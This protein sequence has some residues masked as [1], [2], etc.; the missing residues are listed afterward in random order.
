MR[1]SQIISIAFTFLCWIV[2]YAP[3]YAQSS[4]EE[5]ELLAFLVRFYETCVQ[6]DAEAHFQ[7]WARSSPQI[8]SRR[9]ELHTL[10]GNYEELKGVKIHFIENND[11]VTT[12]WFITD[13]QIVNP[14]TTPQKH[15]ISILRVIECV[16]EN[17]E[18][19]VWRYRPAS[20]VLAEKL[21]VADSSEERQRIVQRYHSFV[22]PD[23]FPSL[24]SKLVPQSSY[25]TIAELLS[26]IEKGTTI[27]QDIING[28]QPLQEARYQQCVKAARILLA[29]SLRAK[30]GLIRDLG[31]MYTPRTLL[32]Q[33]LVLAR[34][35]NHPLLEA[36]VLNDLGGLRIAFGE[37]AEGIEQMERGLLL[38]KQ[39]LERA[40]ADTAMRTGYFV[41]ANHLASAYV[42]LGVLSKGQE[43][44]KDVL[45][46]A[47]AL[48]EKGKLGEMG[49]LW[50]LGNIEY[51]FGRLKSAAEYYQQSLDLARSVNHIGWIVSNLSC[52]IDLLVQQGKYQ[53]AI[54]L[55]EEIVQQGERVGWTNVVMGGLLHLV[56]IHLHLRQYEH[57]RRYIR[58][59]QQI[60]VSI[61]PKPWELPLLQGRLLLQQGRPADALSYFK[62][63][64]TLYERADTTRQLQ[65][66]PLWNLRPS[67]ISHPA[68]YLA[69]CYL[70][71]GRAKDALIAWEKVQGQVL[72]QMP[73][74]RR[75]HLLEELPPLDKQQ[76]QEKEQRLR[77][78]TRVLQMMSRQA[79]VD[80]RLLQQA[81]LRV[82]QARLEYQAVRQ[83]LSIRYPYVKSLYHDFDGD[84]IIKIITS[85]NVAFLRYALYEDKIILYVIFFN[86]TSR[87]AEIKFFEITISQSSLQKMVESLLTR[88]ENRAIQLPETRWL[89]RYLIKPAESLLQKV[90]ILVIVPDGFLWYLPFQSLQDGKGRYLVEQYTICYTSSI[91]AFYTMLQ[92]E[93]V[94]RQQNGTRTPSLLALACSRFEAKRNL[95]LRGRYTPLPNTEKEVRAIAPFFKGHSRIYLNDA[96]TEERIRRELSSA[97]VVHIATHC[98]LNSFQPLYSGIILSLDNDD[99]YDGYLEAREIM[100]MDL[101]HVRLV[102]LSACN[103]ARGIPHPTEGM[104]GFIWAL[105][106]AGVKTSVLTQWQVVDESTAEMMKYFYQNFAKNRG[107]AP[108]QTATALCEAQRRMLRHPKNREWRHPFYWAPFVVIGTGQ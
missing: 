100:E 63:A 17:G 3:C 10:L 23:L 80:K 48:G 71:L 94:Q 59:A 15:S 64:V 28:L 106:A 85:E 82:E 68:K 95:S 60:A 20:E 67:H 96:A 65:L 29:D 76:L 4:T 74:R 45:R 30:A 92:I 107:S 87:S 11:S 73:Q 43:L 13:L 2:A 41:A 99:R 33:A 101:R 83:L 98:E 79:R 103:T 8:E 21:F 6:H 31:D 52:M 86:N 93:G 25:P 24:V 47:Q 39:L 72:R 26:L 46:Q 38:R 14:E 37:Y 91:F 19:R 69:L 62:E 34:D 18:W 53:K 58:E 54:S 35:M 70:R 78:A 75:V 84:K 102:V 36:E 108:F 32:E 66:D 27:T 56:R 81:E 55:A 88:I 50:G 16:R 40:P 104:T 9:K 97:E 42:S 5:A 61:N 49:A 22:D 44:Y 12:L 89:Y 105:L 1:Q 57:A 77:D 7:L 51:A 90:K